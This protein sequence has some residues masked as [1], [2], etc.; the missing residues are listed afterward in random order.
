MATIKDVAKV[1]GVSISTVS[2]ALS[3]KIYVNPETKQR[4]MQAVD[5][6][7]YRPNMLAKGLKEGKTRTIGLLIPDITNLYYARVM[8]NIEKY[9]VKN[10]YSL[11]LSNTN[12]D[13][14]Q[15]ILAVDM[16]KE[17]LVDGMIIIPST[18]DIQHFLA[19][20][21]DGIPFVMLNRRFQDDINCVSNDQRGG[22][23]DAVKYLIEHGHRKISVVLRSFQKQIYQDRYEGCMEALYEHGLQDSERYFLLNV[24]TIEDSRCQAIEMLKR[25]DRPTVFFVTNDMLVFGIYSAVSALNMNIPQD[26]SVMGFDNLPTSPYLVPPL[27]TYEHALEK[28]A[29]EAFRTLMRQINHKQKMAEKIFLR[30]SIITRESVRTIYH[31]VKTEVDSAVLVEKRHTVSR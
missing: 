28:I 6:L 3:E 20:Q 7:G 17:R 10:G 25:E 1:A 8:Q 31:D 26:V 11:L 9:A 14:G 23:Y 27:T 24:D 15:E 19:L 2:R 16:L 29:G 30:G 5:E 13:V 22:A 21:A 12:E 4:V 18:S